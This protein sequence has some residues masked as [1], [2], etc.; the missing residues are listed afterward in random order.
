VYHLSASSAKVSSNRKR[1]LRWFGSVFNAAARVLVSRGNR[2]LRQFRGGSCAVR[3]SADQH[4]E[5]IHR[6]D[7]LLPPTNRCFGI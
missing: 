1:Y 2:L 3:T 5:A 7:V 4:V 6:S